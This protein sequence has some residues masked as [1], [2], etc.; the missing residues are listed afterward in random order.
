MSNCPLLTAAPDR[1]PEQPVFRAA[2]F[3]GAASRHVIDE[4]AARTM[5]PCSTAAYRVVN[6]IRGFSAPGATGDPTGDAPEVAVAVAAAVAVA[7]DWQGSPTA[8]RASRHTAIR[9]RRQP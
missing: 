8:A 6:G 5:P 2:F 4:L 1:A 7:V 9:R 3:A